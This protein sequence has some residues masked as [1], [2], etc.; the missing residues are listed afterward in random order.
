MLM[1]ITTYHGITFTASGNVINYTGDGSGI[2]VTVHRSDTGE[3]IA[4]ATT[5]IGGAYTVTEVFDTNI[6]HFSEARQDGTHLGRSD[7]YTPV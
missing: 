2:T 4:T 7:L 6:T 5:A 1:A 3:K